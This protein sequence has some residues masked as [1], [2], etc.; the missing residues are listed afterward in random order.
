L[1]DAE[2]SAWMYVAVPRKPTTALQKAA[3]VAGLFDSA[4]TYARYFVRISL[5]GGAASSFLYETDDP[6]ESPLHVF[7]LMQVDNVVKLSVPRDDALSFITIDDN[8]DALLESIHG[9][10]GIGLEFG[11]ATG[12][13][14]LA[15]AATDDRDAWF[16]WFSELVVQRELN[17]IEAAAFDER[18]GIFDGDADRN[19]VAPLGQSSE[20]KQLVRE[21]TRK[22]LQNSVRSSRA[23]EVPAR[24]KIDVQPPGFKAYIAC[25]ASGNMRS[26]TIT[27]KA[28]QQRLFGRKVPDSLPLAESSRIIATMP[29]KSEFVVYQSDF[30]GWQFNAKSVEERNAFVQFFRLVKGR[31]RMSQTEHETFPYLSSAEVAAAEAEEAT[32]SIVKTLNQHGSFVYVSRPNEDDDDY[33]SSDSNAS[34]IISDGLAIETKKEA[35]PEA[36]ELTFDRALEQFP[37][38]LWTTMPDL[39]SPRSTDSDKPR[40]VRQFKPFAGHFDLVTLAYIDE[41]CQPHLL[42][43]RNFRLT[44]HP[45]SALAKQLAA[46]R[47]ASAAKVAGR[48]AALRSPSRDGRK[49][50]AYRAVQHEGRTNS[51]RPIAAGTPPPVVSRSAVLAPPHTPPPRSLPGRP[52]TPNR[53]LAAPVKEACASVD[54]SRTLKLGLQRL[55]I[56]PEDKE[57]LRPRADMGPQYQYHDPRRAKTPTT[58]LRPLLHQ[59]TL[60]DSDMVRVPKFLF[61]NP[62]PHIALSAHIGPST[63]R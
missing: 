1:D 29:W 2:E 16:K 20:G 6:D 5:R 4:G 61:S 31:G 37:H 51:P 12:T 14:R 19:K 15:L 58:T 27:I 46:Q 47:D 36:Q 48:P 7:D 57:R 9:H 21:Y 40:S 28:R 30:E 42:G 56:A 17:A 3:A 33:S 63:R 25:T 11:A 55:K 39:D 22:F 60:R 35:P 59:N 26:G 13:L 43:R 53:L 18:R 54:T 41:T 52:I 62:A 50:A 49:S 32:R 10:L 34:S 23:D 38:L 24:G 45:K 8:G 44:A